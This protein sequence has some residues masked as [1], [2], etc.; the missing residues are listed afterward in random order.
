M[1]HVIL[2]VFEIA[3]ERAS[4]RG[5]GPEFDSSPEP[6]PMVTAPL[7]AFEAEKAAEYE[8][9]FQAGFAAALHEREQDLQEG[10]QLLALWQE[11]ESRQFS[12][13]RSALLAQMQPLFEAVIAN[14]LPMAARLSL[15]PLAVEHLLTQVQNELPQSL[16]LALHSQD[17]EAIAPF[18][19]DPAITLVQDD[20]LLRG[21]YGLRFQE[22]EATFDIERLC[23]EINEM[24][25]AFFAMEPEIEPEM[26]QPPEGGEDDAN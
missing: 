13:I 9:G 23:A 10:R 26:P 25:R 15:L 4:A 8:R 20:S 6:E 16:C 3:R 14:V 1:R 11:G 5:S 12:A 7:A 24:I 22:I 21:R 2:E 17:Y 19:S 18:I